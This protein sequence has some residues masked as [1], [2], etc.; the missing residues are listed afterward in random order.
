MRALVTTENCLREICKSPSSVWNLIVNKQKNIIISTNSGDNK[1]E[2][3]RFPLRLHNK[4]V[5][6]IPQSNIVNQLPNNPLFLEA[7]SDCIFLL[8]IPK[9]KAEE[10]SRDYGICC[11]SAESKEPPF[12]T[13]EGWFFETTDPDLEKSWDFFYE[14]LNR[15]C[16]SAILIDRF[17]FCREW[18]KGNGC[19]D[20]TIEHSTFNL[21]SI[22]N[23]IIPNS[24]HNDKFVLTIVFNFEGA[25]KCEKKD[26][27]GNVIRDRNGRVQFIYYRFEELVNMI[28]QI[29]KE[30]IRPFKYDIEVLSI[31]KRCAYY[32]DTHDRYVITNFHLT[33]AT[34]KLVAFTPDQQFLH[35]QILNFFYICST[36]LKNKSSLPIATKE[37]V[38]KAM[39]QLI[40]ESD[41]NTL[42]YAINGHVVPV[43]NKSLIKNKLLHE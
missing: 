42:K 28:N 30:I 3:D 4:Q 5:R 15:N 2:I 23:N 32:N 8:E 33:T 12:I 1:F 20:D 37:R 25:I 31:N 17:L 9:A 21:K 24:I 38:L 29:K 6:I 16:T 41:I 10:L 27:L 22:M 26:C 19:P 7:L 39:I 34:H 18:N 40:D 43:F 13:E 11:F 35:K 36:G 14:G